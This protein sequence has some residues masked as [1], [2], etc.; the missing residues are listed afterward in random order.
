MVSIVQI[1][2]SDFDVEFRQKTERDWRMQN[3]A[4]LQ[5]ERRSFIF[6]SDQLVTDYK[7]SLENF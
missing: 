1:L 7:Q 3:D 6:L 2:A 4:S 5:N